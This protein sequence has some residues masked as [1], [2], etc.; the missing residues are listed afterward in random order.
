MPLKTENN[1]WVKA[2]RQ[3]MRA[4]MHSGAAWYV[5]NSRGSVKLEINNYTGSKI[6]EIKEYTSY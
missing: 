1:D 3:A 2:A 4:E 5:S 6:K